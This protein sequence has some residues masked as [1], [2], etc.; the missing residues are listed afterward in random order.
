MAVD[1]EGREAI[2]DWK[3]ISR[4][5][6]VT[7]LDVHILTGRTHQIR[8]HMK[9]IG[10]PV[11]GDPIYGAPKGAKVPRLMLHAYSLA[12]THPATG[13]RMEFTAELP[14]EF[15]TGLKSHGVEA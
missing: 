6:G 4:G 10:H 11:C 14:P 3:V 12:F 2:T 5:R 1:E 15:L 7:L 9:H 8:V 13:E